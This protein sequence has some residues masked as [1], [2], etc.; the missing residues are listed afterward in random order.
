MDNTF[1][2]TAIED[3]QIKAA[4]TFWTDINED[5][6]RNVSIEHGASELV[7]S[8]KLELPS[9]RVEIMSWQ[10][11]II[12]NVI[13]NVLL[14]P[15]PTNISKRYKKELDEEDSENKYLEISRDHS[16]LAKHDF[17]PNPNIDLDI[18]N[19]HCRDE[20]KILVEESLQNSNLEI[21]SGT[22]RLVDVFIGSC[23]WRLKG[24]SNST[25]NIL[26]SSLPNNS[27]LMEVG[28]TGIKGSMSFSEDRFIK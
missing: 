2:K 5:E 10:F 22:A 4:Y 27:V 19:K 8:F 16:L 26:P 7:C 15:P 11:Y 20:L 13:R 25:E 23:I 17:K 12:I 6:I 3:F 21:F 14:V 1:L 9:I 24:S 28:I 18:L